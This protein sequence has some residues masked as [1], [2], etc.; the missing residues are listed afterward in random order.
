MI[1]NFRY[2]IFTI[3]AI[4]A[5]LG[6]GMLIGSSIIGQEGLLEEQKK[7]INNI[8]LDINRLRIENQELKKGKDQL[9]EE[10]A[11][12]QNIERK[13]LSLILNN[14]L[15]DAEYYLVHDQ[16]K[17]SLLN[18]VKEIFSAAEVKISLRLRTIPVK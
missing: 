7:I 6:L 18:D 3:T 16:I 14:L 17:A 4:F 15:N 9:E 12:R 5:A 1:L 8:S 2:H 11:N 10:L 13:Y